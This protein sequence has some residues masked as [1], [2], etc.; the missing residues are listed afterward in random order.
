MKRP[1][2]LKSRSISSLIPPLEWTD[3]GWL[4]TLPS[5]LGSFLGKPIDL[6]IAGYDYESTKPNRA[7]VLFAER[8]LAQLPKILKQA[9]KAL[10]EAVEEEP[11]RWPKNPDPVMMFDF[12]ATDE[13]GWI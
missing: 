5:E 7:V 13:G 12:E 9:E 11:D 10:R 1:N 4:T 6:L 2:A 3:L 8:T